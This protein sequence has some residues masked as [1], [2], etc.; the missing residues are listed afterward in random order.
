MTD[1]ED[2]I[3]ELESRIE[4]LENGG[5]EVGDVHVG[6]TLRVVIADPN[7]ETDRDAFA[8]IDGVATFVKFPDDYTPSLGESVP[9]AIAD[10]ADNT[11]VAV[12]QE[13]RLD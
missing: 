4:A 5:K 3:D 10:V 11:I 7:T 9:V 2:R 6:D 8:R 13:D 1:I 12:A